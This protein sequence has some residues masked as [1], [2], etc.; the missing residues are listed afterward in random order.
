MCMMLHARNIPVL[1]LR[2]RGSGAWDD[3]LQKSRPA[4]AQS[5][6]LISGSRMTALI[7]NKT[8]LHLQL[9]LDATAAA[10]IMNGG[11]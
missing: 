10:A 7:A 3:L 6:T 9:Q 4:T 1:L 2:G 11:R 8:Q 5:P